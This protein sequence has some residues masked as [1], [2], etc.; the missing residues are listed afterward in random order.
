MLTVWVT[1][2]LPITSP[3]SSRSR[4]SSFETFS[5]SSYLTCRLRQI[6]QLDLLTS[7]SSQ[8]RAVLVERLFDSAAA[9]LLSPAGQPLNA[10]RMPSAAAASLALEELRS[11]RAQVLAAIMQRLA[12]PSFSALKVC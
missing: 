8:P 7:T 12:D 5:P 1:G 4:Y 3:C 11:V 6:H 2:A 9:S 10:S